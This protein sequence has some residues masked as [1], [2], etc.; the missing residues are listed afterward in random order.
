MDAG[1]R[2]GIISIRTAAKDVDQAIKD[3]HAAALG[4]L[5]HR[6]HEQPFI[7]IRS[8]AVDGG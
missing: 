6:R 4:R 7:R 2:L 5:R 3:T 1:G 8:V